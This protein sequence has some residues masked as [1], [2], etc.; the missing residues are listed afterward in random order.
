MVLKELER[1]T[2][3]VPHIRSATKVLTCQ[4][5]I[6]EPIAEVVLYSRSSC[7]DISPQHVCTGQV[8]FRIQAGSILRLRCV[9]GSGFLGAGASREM[10]RRAL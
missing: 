4:V 7:H 8:V 2:R 1:V 3:L 10:G 9:R 5:G 6:I